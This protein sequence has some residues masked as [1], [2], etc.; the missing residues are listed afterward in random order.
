MLRMKHL[1]L[2]RE[3]TQRQ[4]AELAEIPHPHIC[5][6]ERARMIPTPEQLRRLG[7]VFKCP[8]D[9]LLDHVAPT[10]AEHRDAQREEHANG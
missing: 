9:R 6:I 7:K 2:L 1:R 8:P 5:Y 4:V 10:G 3:W